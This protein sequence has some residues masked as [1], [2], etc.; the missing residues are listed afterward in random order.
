MEFSK[1][2]ITPRHERKIYIL[3]CDLCGEQASYIVDLP[4]HM[5]THERKSHV[6]PKCGGKWVK[7]S[8]EYEY[9]D[10]EAIAARQAAKL[11]RC[12]VTK[13]FSGYRTDNPDGLIEIRCCKL[14][15]DDQNHDFHIGDDY[16]R[17]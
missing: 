1:F 6:G 12:M 3:R 16:V 11:T 5:L 13:V 8:E 15:H 4:E 9:N 2:K 14:R 17:L 10:D 7:Q